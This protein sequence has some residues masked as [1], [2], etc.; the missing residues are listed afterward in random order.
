MVISSSGRGIAG[1]GGVSRAATRPIAG[2]GGVMRPMPPIAGGGGMHRPPFPHPRP[3]FPGG[4]G[5]PGFIGG[6]FIPFGYNWNPGSNLWLYPPYNYPN[7]WTPYMTTYPL[8]ANTNYVIGM[9]ALDS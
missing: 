4:G 9:T 1:G 7:L 6:G 8:P 3:P 5:S 2:G